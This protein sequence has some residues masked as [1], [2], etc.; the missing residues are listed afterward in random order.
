MNL[1]GFYAIYR[2][3][4]ARMWRTVMQSVLSPVLSHITPRLGYLAPTVEFPD[5][6]DRLRRYVAYTPLNN[7]AGSPAISLPAGLSP[8][9]LPVGVQ[10][11]GAYGDE[12][13]LLELAFLLEAERPFARIQEVASACRA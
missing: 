11:S 4:M 8:D 12:R 1:R 5:L 2:F 7:I 13:T 9:G 10:L 3:E 6:I